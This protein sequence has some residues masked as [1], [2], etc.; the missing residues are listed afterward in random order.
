[1]YQFLNDNGNWGYTFNI[2][3]GE[4]PYQCSY[5]YCRRWGKQ[6]PLHFDEKELKTNLG[7]GNFIFVGSSCD[8][9]ALSIPYHWIKKQLALCRLFPNNR[10]LFQS[11]N[12]ARFN[13]FQFPPNTILGTTIET[14][15]DYRGISKAPP[16]WS[17]LL[18]MTDIEDYPKMVS[19]EPIMDFD[20]VILV[21]WIK[22]IQPEFVS[23]GADSKGH[24]LPEPALDKVLALIEELRA[25][26]KLHIKGNLKRI[27]NKK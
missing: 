26:T 9:F 20:L 11:K 12:P 6:A 1:M 5:C 24:N 23:I 18:A 16:N 21:D 7:E 17:R 10:Y 27:L 4:C 2:I 15:K 25:I 22:A 8:D 13:L 3:K 19:I 14:N